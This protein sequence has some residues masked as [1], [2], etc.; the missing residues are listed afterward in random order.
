VA[1]T[2]LLE[3]AEWYCRCFR[4]NKAFRPKKKGDSKLQLVNEMPDSVNEKC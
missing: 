2:S 3:P 4:C 1:P